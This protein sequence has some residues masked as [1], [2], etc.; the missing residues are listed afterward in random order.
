MVA[1]ERV[2]MSVDLPAP[3]S[4]TTARISPLTRSKS[5]SFVILAVGPDQYLGRGQ[6][7]RCPA[8]M[9]VG[10]ISDTSGLLHSGLKLASHLRVASAL[11]FLLTTESVA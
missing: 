6:T 9:T 1:P 11:P 10:Y 5:A 7:S 8:L 4:P 2:L 3:L